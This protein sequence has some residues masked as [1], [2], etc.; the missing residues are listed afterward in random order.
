MNQYTSWV[1]LGISEL[2][3]FKKCFVDARQ[4]VHALKQALYFYSLESNWNP[5]NSKDFGMPFKGR[6]FSS[7]VSVD[8]GALARAALLNIERKEKS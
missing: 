6:S 2:E 5:R 1:E 7:I 4:E 8:R 3:Y